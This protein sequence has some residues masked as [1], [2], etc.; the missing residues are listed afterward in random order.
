[1]E[2]LKEIFLSQKQR[3]IL[4]V[5]QDKKKKDYWQKEAEHE[6]QVRFCMGSTWLFISG[7]PVLQVTNETNLANSTIA[8]QQL[9]DFISATRA[10]FV[11][12][13]LNCPR[14]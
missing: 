11:L 12:S 14:I 1:M 9:S 10:A 13:H 8:L 7:T 3:D 5:R 2:L 6:I 4:Q